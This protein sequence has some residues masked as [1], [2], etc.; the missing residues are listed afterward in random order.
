MSIANIFVRKFKKSKE[1]I[2][3]RPWRLLRERFLFQN[4][5]KSGKISDCYSIQLMKERGIECLTILSTC[6]LVL[7][8]T[9]DGKDNKEERFFFQNCLKSEKISD[10]YSIRLMKER[11]IECH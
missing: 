1:V 10:C 8:D 5:L 11:G 9:V 3:K 7:D 6:E 2:L 4:C